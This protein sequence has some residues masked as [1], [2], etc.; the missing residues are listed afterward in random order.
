[1]AGADLL[2]CAARSRDE[3]PALRGAWLEPG[4]TVISIGSTVPEQRELDV[5]AIAGAD[6]VVADQVHEVLRTRRSHARHSS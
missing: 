3:Q 6:V 5:E 1:V 4:M 2:V